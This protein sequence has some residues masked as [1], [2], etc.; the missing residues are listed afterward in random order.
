M[1]DEVS[2]KL[3]TAESAKKLKK[4]TIVTAEIAQK[5]NKIEMFAN[6]CK[7]TFSVRSHWLQL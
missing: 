2:N 6:I 7:D 3:N 5:G 4:L 1:K